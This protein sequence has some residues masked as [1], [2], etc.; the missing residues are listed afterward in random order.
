MAQL[1]SATTD[2]QLKEATSLVVASF[3]IFAYASTITVDAAEPDQVAHLLAS[4]ARYVQICA[5]CSAT[6]KKIS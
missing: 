6:C 3:N 1:K 2:T 5:A 4:P